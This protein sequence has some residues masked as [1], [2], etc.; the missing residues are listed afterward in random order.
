M[1]HPAIR[2]SRHKVLPLYLEAV[3]T[4]LYPSITKARAGRYK[5]RQSG[6]DKS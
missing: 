3:T 6:L 1:F 2:R 5:R 4:Y